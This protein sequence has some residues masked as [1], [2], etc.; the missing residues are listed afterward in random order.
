MR[1]IAG[2]ILIVAATILVI[3]PAIAKDQGFEWVAPFVCAIG[4]LGLFYLFSGS[5]HKKEPEKET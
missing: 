2:A 4:V 1:Q 5:R 3:P